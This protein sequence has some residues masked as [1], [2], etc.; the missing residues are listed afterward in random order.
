MTAS[1]E[2]IVTARAEISAQR[3]EVALYRAL[4][5]AALRAPANEEGR[6]LL[7]RCVDF[8]ERRDRCWARAEREVSQVANGG[9]LSKQSRRTARDDG[10]LR[11]EWTELRAELVE[12]AK[13]GRL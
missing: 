13:A 10:R 1:R 7:E 6:E 4:F 12:L 2:K 3:D 8:C 9:G 11:R 5:E